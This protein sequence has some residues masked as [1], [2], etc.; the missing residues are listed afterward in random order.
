MTIQCSE[1]GRTWRVKGPFR[2]L[3]PALQ[4]NFKQPTCRTSR[5]TRMWCWSLG[6][7]CPVFQVNVMPSSSWSLVSLYFLTPQRRDYHP[8]NIRNCSPNDTAA[9]LSRLE[10]SVPQLWEPKICF[11]GMKYKLLLCS[12]PSCIMKLDVLLIERDVLWNFDT[13]MSSTLQNLPQHCSHICSRKCRT[14]SM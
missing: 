4:D 7:L 11:R 13:W 2:S 10:S 5:S 1:A 8:T 9:H 14:S 6:N 12:R 3:R